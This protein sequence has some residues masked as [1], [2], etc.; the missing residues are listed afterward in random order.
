MR[1][2]ADTFALGH[3]GVVDAVAFSADGKR[4]ASV[5]SD[6]S[7]RLWDAATGRPLRV[8]RA[9]E[10]NRPWYLVAVLDIT[11][12]GRWILS[13]G[14]EERLKLWDAWSEKVVRTIALPPRQTDRPDNRPILQV[15]ISA[16][17]SRAVG[18]FGHPGEKHKLATRDLKTGQLLACHSV[19]NTMPG[20][21][22][23]SA[24]GRLL[25]CNGVLVDAASGKKTA[26]LQ[27]TSTYRC[28]FSR[29]GA[30]VFGI[31]RTVQKDGKP[32]KM[33]D[34]LRG[35]ECATGK[36][37][38]HLK[39]KPWTYQAAFH[40][41]NRILMTNDDGI[42]LHDAVT[43]KLLAVHRM[44]K[45]VMSS[46]I[47]FAFTSDGRRLATGM[48]DG[49]ILMWDISLPASKP[50]RL[51]AKEIESLWTD[52]A[53]ADAAKAWR[54]VWR[55]AEA[56]HD[57]LSFLRGRVKSYPTASADVTRKLLAD[58]D[59]DSF[60][61]REEA[62]NRLKELGLQAEA[63]LHEA[64]KAKPS[65]EQKRRIELILAAL[66]ETPEPLSGEEL[67]QLRALIVLERI[68]SPEARRMLENV[69]NGPASARR[70][71]QAQ[72]A[73]MAGTTR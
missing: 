24:D 13:A 10:P 72:A 73:L 64:L 51:E 34:G 48:P 71:R 43:G 39:S 16:D 11:P 60:E 27:G 37:V 17:G 5:S 20:Y 42:Q 33:A 70:T 28:A 6:G 59:S 36:I 65:L 63:A 23:L 7:V 29:D 49:T 8:W 53:D 40:P 31:L 21:R 52:L 45:D 15:R 25:L 47:G 1:F 3:I 66:R 30:L 41:N 32:P 35:W 38:A 62:E 19:E 61:R 44:P 54:A 9:H 46:A 69:A 12:D 50:Q 4:L 14:G 26:R 58:L 57:A 18:L 55:M 67:R 2:W 22:A 68:G 56:P